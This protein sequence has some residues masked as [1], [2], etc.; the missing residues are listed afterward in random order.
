MEVGDELLVMQYPDVHD[1][2]HPTELKTKIYRIDGAKV[3][4]RVDPTLDTHRF[5]SGAVL[6]KFFKQ[7]Q[8]YKIIGFHLGRTK[9]IDGKPIQWCHNG[10]LLTFALQRMRLDIFAMEHHEAEAS[11]VEVRSGEERKMRVGAMPFLTPPIPRVDAG[12]A[13]GGELQEDVY[14]CSQERP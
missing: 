11:Q 7:E 8:R 2:Q 10:I 14:A 1:N 3:Y 12:E 6:V 13:A 5:V 9:E 4:Y